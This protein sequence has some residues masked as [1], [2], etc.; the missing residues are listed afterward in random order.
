MSTR[1]GASSLVLRLQTSIENT[2]TVVGTV[3][4]L[5]CR[6]NPIRRA[7]NGA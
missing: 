6:A 2:L 3:S 1:F 4:P 7:C 5:I